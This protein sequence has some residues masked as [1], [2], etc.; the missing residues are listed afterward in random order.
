M[1]A[2]SE[3]APMIRRRDLQRAL[4]VSSLTRFPA[5]PELPA[6]AESGVPGYE[7]G[8]IT[9]VFAPAKT[10]PAIVNRLR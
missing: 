8:V 10:P 3:V 5:F 7:A 6:I 4:G 2:I 1:P 9:G